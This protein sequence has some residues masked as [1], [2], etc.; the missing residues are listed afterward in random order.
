MHDPTPEVSLLQFS[1]NCAIILM[2]MQLAVILPG[3][4]DGFVLEQT[5]EWLQ[6]RGAKGIILTRFA[7]T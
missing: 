4:N 2:Y 1:K 5:C 6:D 7:N 3:I